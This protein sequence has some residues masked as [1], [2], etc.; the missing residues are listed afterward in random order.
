[1]I[2]FLWFYGNFEFVNFLWFLDFYNNILFCNMSFYIYLFDCKQYI[3]VRKYIYCALN[4]YIHII[5]GAKC[6]AYTP[7][8]IYF[9]VSILIEI[10]VKCHMEN[11]SKI[12]HYCMLTV[13]LPDRP[14]PCTPFIILLCL[15]PDDFIH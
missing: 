6:F 12:F 9:L 4:L 1:M 5:I 14:K 11:T 3:R 13:S 8:N 10:G 7:S 2:L 15:T